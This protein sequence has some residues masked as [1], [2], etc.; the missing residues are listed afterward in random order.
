MAKKKKKQQR[1]KRSLGWFIFG[2]VLY[3]AVFLGAV[4]YGLKYL[5]IYLEAYENS[6]PYHAIDAYMEQLTKEYISQCAEDMIA[7]VD[8]NLQ[9]EEECMQVVMDAIEGEITYARKASEC[10][11][12]KQVYVVRCGELV[13]GSFAIEAGEADQYGFTPWSPTEDRYDLSHL[14][15]ETIITATA[16]AGYPVYV[17]GVQLDESYIVREETTPYDVFEEFYD[18]YDLPSFTVVTYEAGPFM[19]EFQMEVTDPDGNPYVY[20]E[21]LDINSLVDNCT[22]DEIDAL[23]EFINEYIKRYVVFTGSANRSENSNYANLVELMVPTST[24]SQRMKDAIDGLHW[25]QSKGDQIES[26][27]VNHYVNIGDNRYLCDVT[28]IVDTTGLEGVVQ[29]TNNVKIIIVENDG[30]FLAEAMT[31][32]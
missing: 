10:T 6:R 30:T 26:I 20:D 14:L 19:S 4:G 11:D 9:S 31:S 7:Q 12:T 27:T 3:A 22:E 16:P 21:N 23:D 29:T 2:M 8:H 32:Y 5:W 18:D 24:L 13:V 28:Y 17:N 1:K 15:N 25:A